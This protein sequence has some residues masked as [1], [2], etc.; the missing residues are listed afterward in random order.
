MSTRI[1]KGLKTVVP[2][3]AWCLWLTGLPGS[4]KSTIARAMSGKLKKAGISA[5]TISSDAIRR[6]MT[7]RP[8]YTE[9]ERDAVYDAIVSVAREFVRN[10]TNVIID[11]T[12]NRRRYRDRARKKIKRFFEAYLRCPLKVCMEREARRK[13]TFL[14]PK[15]IYKKAKEGRSPTVPGMGAPYERPLRPD[16]I[17]DTN[18][19]GPDEC[20]EAVIKAI[21]PN[22]Y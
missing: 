5:Y 11:A 15:N 16:V 13:R 21:F 6:V 10:G 4:G 14:A 7:P 3:K 1:F 18:R 12:A 22:G 20:V 9:E 19:L 2:Q 8:K 17:V